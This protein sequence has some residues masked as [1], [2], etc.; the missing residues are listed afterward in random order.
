M[1]ST[2][3]FGFMFLFSTTIFGQ[4]A[5][6]KQVDGNIDLKVD[7]YARVANSIWHLAELGI[8]SGGEWGGVAMDKEGVM[9]VNANEMP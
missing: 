3:L 2:L 9:Y 6:K 4:T 7:E 5:L 1:K 8:A